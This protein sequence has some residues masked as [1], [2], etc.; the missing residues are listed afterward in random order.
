MGINFPQPKVK[1]IFI[2]IV[3]NYSPIHHCKFNG[4]RSFRN[5]CRY[6]S[7]K[8]NPIILKTP[9]GFTLLQN[10]SYIFLFSF[11]RKREKIPTK[12]EE[13]PKREPTN[14]ILHSSIERWPRTS[15]HPNQAN[16]F[17]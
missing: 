13:G 15:F 2:L 9:E 4:S 3:I 11:S 12:R 1:P 7:S 10:G 16:K 8:S 6:E 14:N 17:R 5:Q